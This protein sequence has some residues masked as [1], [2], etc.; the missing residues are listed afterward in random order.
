VF[1]RSYR[2]T[3][4]QHALHNLPAEERPTDKDLAD[5]TWKE[6]TDHVKL[7]DPEEKDAPRSNMRLENFYPWG[8]NRPIWREDPDYPSFYGNHGNWYV[9]QAVRSRNDSY[10]NGIQR[11]T[12]KGISVGNLHFSDLAKD[13]TEVVCDAVTFGRVGRRIVI[14]GG[15]F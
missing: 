13:E 11:Q 6:L 8:V 14:T 1:S 9:G 2:L 7:L 3:A 5:I 4:G 12:M 10:A 15:L